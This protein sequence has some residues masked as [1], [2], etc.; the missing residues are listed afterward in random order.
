MAEQQQQPVA[1]PAPAAAPPPLAVA[2][3]PVVRGWADYVPLAALAAV[4][5][6]LIAAAIVH[7]LTGPAGGDGTGAGGGGDEFARLAAANAAWPATRG[8]TVPGVTMVNT[9][10]RGVPAATIAAGGVP[11]NLSFPYCDRMVENATRVWLRKQ[12][13]INREAEQFTNT[14]L[15]KNYYMRACVPSPRRPL[16]A[17]RRAFEPWHVHKAREDP[18]LPEAY[19]RVNKTVLAQLQPRVEHVFMDGHGRTSVRVVFHDMSTNQLTPVLLDL[20]GIESALNAAWA[21]LLAAYGSLQLVDPPCICPHHFYIYGS[22]LAFVLR[23]GAWTTW[24]RPEYTGLDKVAA[25]ARAYTYMEWLAPGDIGLR[26]SM[27]RSPRVTAADNSTAGGTVA[28]RHKVSYHDPAPLRDLTRARQS[29]AFLEYF[30][31]KRLIAARGPLSASRPPPTAMVRRGDEVEEEEND[32]DDDFVDGDGALPA[33]VSPD[34]GGG[35]GGGGEEEEIDWDDDYHDYDHWG[36]SN[37][38]SRLTFFD[39]SPTGGGGG[40]GGVPVV[41]RVA[42]AETSAHWARCHAYCQAYDKDLYDGVPIY[43]T[44]V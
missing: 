11:S 43:R 9:D 41:P 8:E 1:P 5:L 4:G 35:G 36:T 27:L 19:A 13:K 29:H 33:V 16:W 37:I 7:N 31:N 23:D 26:H 22:E 44:R 17:A 18:L 40:G 32:D 42:A 30:V 3:K 20:A 28:T 10:G 14:N 39:I 24:I 34:G 25:A 6:A 2:A 12:R 15:Y 21:D 38:A